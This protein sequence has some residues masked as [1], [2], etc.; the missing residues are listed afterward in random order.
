[1]TIISVYDFSWMIPSAIMI[2]LWLVM[3]VHIY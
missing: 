2:V 3:L 1:M